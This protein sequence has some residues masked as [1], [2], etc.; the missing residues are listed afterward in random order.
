MRHLYLKQATGISGIKASLLGCLLLVVCA[1][2]ST[3]QVRINEVLVRPSLGNTLSD[4]TG[5]TN[6]SEYVEIFNI[7]KCDTI[8]LSCYIIGANMS[9]NNSAAFSFPAGTKLSPLDFVVVGG[10][11]QTPVD[12]DWDIICSGNTYCGS[13][14]FNLPD[15]IG[16]IAVYDAA[17]TTIDAVFWTTLPGQ[18]GL[19]TTHPAFQDA[20]CVPSTC[21]NAGTLKSA[22]TMVAGLEIQYAGEAPAADAVIARS[23]DGVG[24]WLTNE[25]PSPGTCNGV[26]IPPT[27]LFV[28]FDTLQNETCMLANGIIS[29][30]VTGGVSPY[31]Y[32]WNDQENDPTREELV[33]GFYAVTVFDFDGC[34]FSISDTLVNVGTPIDATIDPEEVTIFEGDAIQLNVVTDNNIVSAPWSP[35]TSLSCIDCTDPVASPRET[36]TYSVNLE[37][38]DGCLGSASIQIKVLKDENSVFVATAFTPNGDGENDILFVRSPRI[39]TLDFHLF[40]RWGQEVFTTTDINVGWDGKDKKGKDAN[41]GVYVYY[42]D[43]VLT[44]GT[45]RTI[46]GNVTLLR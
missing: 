6:S 29:T 4:C 16:W 26:C 44:N 24:N 43:V 18:P 11:G 12:F 5:A 22:S 20:P 39:A 27:D 46:K 13:P 32:E 1:A 8:D 21:T 37:D 45:E 42:C 25:S 30:E 31:R 9:A 17:G 19:L 41:V 33:A 2:V 35:T 34:Q 10:N 38:S 28:S 40:D 3:A 7:S 15:T 23:T 36:T 14:T